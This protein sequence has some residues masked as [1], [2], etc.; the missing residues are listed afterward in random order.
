MNKAEYSRR[1]MAE[2]LIR[3]LKTHDYQ[4]LTIQQIVD[5]AKVS[6]MAF[7]R[8]FK[9]KDEILKYHLDRITDDYIA[10]THIR[11]LEHDLTDYLHTL[12]GHLME[13]RGIGLTLVKAGLFDY[14]RA[15]FD[16]AYESMNPAVDAQ[17]R[18]RF[19]FIAGGM[20]NVYYQW[21]VGGC[22]ESVE[23]LTEIMV[24]ALSAQDR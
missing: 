10:R 7:Y 13:H 12:L 19:H 18:Y 3:L 11:I 5:E 8:N 14:M 16:R 9:S 1:S 2:A 20:C 15:E 21:L 6:R 24:H 23:E 4:S 17:T 22:R